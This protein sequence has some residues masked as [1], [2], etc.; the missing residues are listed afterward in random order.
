M[1]VSLVDMTASRDTAIVLHYVFVFLLPPYPVFGALY[2]IDSVSIYKY[3]S[4]TNV[5]RDFQPQFYLI[6]SKL[7]EI[8]V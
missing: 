2:Y 6:S 7:D 8:W 5:Q 4:F 3:K 1:T